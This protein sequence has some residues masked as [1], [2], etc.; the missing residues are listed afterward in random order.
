MSQMAFYST[1]LIAQTYFNYAWQFPSVED[2]FLS[3]F[4]GVPP[5]SCNPGQ[6]TPYW[7]TSVQYE[8]ANNNQGFILYVNYGPSLSRWNLYKFRLIV[9]VGKIGDPKF[10]FQL[11]VIDKNGNSA[12][13]ATGTLN[14]CQ[15]LNC[16]MF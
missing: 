9:P 5:P 8:Q 2:F 12:D 1:P 11:S 16:S 14:R 10:N 13:L 7:A 3:L 15:S 4:T 6:F